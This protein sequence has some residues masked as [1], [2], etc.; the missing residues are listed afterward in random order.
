MKS[1]ASETVIEIGAASVP[2]PELSFSTIDS[3]DCYTTISAPTSASSVT[4]WA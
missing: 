3:N 2:R 4:G 1:A